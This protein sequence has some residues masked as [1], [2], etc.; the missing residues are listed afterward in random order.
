MENKIDIRGR[1]MG[2]LVRSG[3]VEVNRKKQVLRK[4]MERQLEREPKLMGG[5]STKIYKARTKETLRQL[6]WLIL[7]KTPSNR[8]YET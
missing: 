5:T 4:Q 1:W 7:D 2:E 6:M 8:G 3:F